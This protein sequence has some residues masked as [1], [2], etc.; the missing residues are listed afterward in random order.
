[1][2]PDTLL[3]L[4]KNIQHKYTGRDKEYWCHLGTEQLSS[5][6]RQISLRA[7]KTITTTIT[8]ASVR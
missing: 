3:A 7:V 1:M 2:P 5:I 6:L 4:S 8:I